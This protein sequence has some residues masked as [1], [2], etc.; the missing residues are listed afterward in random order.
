VNLAA[1]LCGHAS[2][3]FIVVSKAM[4]DAAMGDRRLRFNSK[5]RVTIRGLK[6]LVT[7][8]TLSAP[9]QPAL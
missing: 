9:E 5:R 1:R 7:V 3:I 4:R 6:D 8:Y 2:P